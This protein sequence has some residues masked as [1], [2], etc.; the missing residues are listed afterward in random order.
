MQAVEKRRAGWTIITAALLCAGAILGG[1]EL[2]TNDS[3]GTGW[4]LLV[5]FG[6]MSTFALFIWAEIRHVRRCDELHRR[7]ML[8]SLAIAF[9][10]SFA[11]FTLL[12]LLGDGELVSHPFVVEEAWPLMVVLWIFAYGFAR[13]RYQ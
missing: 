4:K 6:V 11:A 5:V 9:P 3:L 2:V 7:I 10:A 8:E 13:W 1:T 12:E